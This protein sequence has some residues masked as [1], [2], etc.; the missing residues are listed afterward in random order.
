M[1]IETF[2]GFL[3]NIRHGFSTKAPQVQ[4]PPY[5]GRRLRRGPEG[6]SRPRFAAIP[7]GGGVDLH[8]GVDATGIPLYLSHG[9][10]RTPEFSNHFLHDHIF[11]G[12]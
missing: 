9:L 1:T 2:L 7:L 4:T 5:R 3:P 11:R 6:L 12:S 8:G 10:K